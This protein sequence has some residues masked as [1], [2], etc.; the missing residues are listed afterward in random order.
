MKREPKNVAASVQARLLQRTR[1]LNVEHQLTLARFG[2]E[3]LLYRLSKS[4]FSDRFILKGA[5]LLLLWLGE[6]IRPTKDVDLLGF[7]DTSVEALKRIFTGLCHIDAPGDGLR[8]VTET[9]RVEA[10]REGQE[11]G[12][13]RVTRRCRSH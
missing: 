12:G 1:A 6:A 9:V 13:M 11:Y 4:E 7:G 5:A 8:F 3:R 2:G 10:I